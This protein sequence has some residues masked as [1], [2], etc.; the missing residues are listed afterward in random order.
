MGGKG[1]REKAT[2][3]EQEYSVSGSEY[4][5]YE[6]S[7]VGQGEEKVRDIRGKFSDMGLS[8]KASLLADDI[9][10]ET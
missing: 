9:L 10:S 5:F 7:Q 6:T 3:T 2:D 8:G 1:R 4:V